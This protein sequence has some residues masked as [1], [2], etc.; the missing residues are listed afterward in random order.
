MAQDPTIPEIVVDTQQ[1]IDII[2]EST[3]ATLTDQGYIY[4]QAGF[5]YNQIG[6]MYGGLNQR[7]EDIAPIFFNDTTQILS[8]SI[9]SL[10]DNNI[11]PLLFG[12]SATLLNPS[13]S[14]IID[15]GKRTSAGQLMGILG[16]TY[17]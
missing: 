2:I 17:P 10:I 4:N 16:L 7:N 3:D 12:D 9:K 11:T 1:Q 14:S 5:T 13:I 6:I 15:I 8:P